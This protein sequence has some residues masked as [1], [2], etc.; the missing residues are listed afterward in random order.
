MTRT[1]HTSWALRFARAFSF[2]V[3]ASVVLYAFASPHSTAPAWHL[4]VGALVTG[5]V[6]AL[7]DLAWRAVRRIANG[8]Q[9]YHDSAPPD[10]PGRVIINLF[11]ADG[12]PAGAPGQPPAR[13]HNG[14]VTRRSA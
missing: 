1:Q 13:G 7:A 10:E 14:P 3:A 9:S 8:P 5:A 4:T 2:G 12:A 11:T 6:I